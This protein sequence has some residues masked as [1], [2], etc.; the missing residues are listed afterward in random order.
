MG[1]P[2]CGVDYSEAGRQGLQYSELFNKEIR[3]YSTYDVDRSL[4]HVFDGLKTSQRKVLFACFKKK[5]KN[6]IKVAQLAGYIGEHSA[7]HHGEQSLHST[8]I[9][10]AQNYVG[11]NN[12]NLL[13]PSGQFGTRRMGGKSRDFLDTSLFSHDISRLS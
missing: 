10:M 3:A 12:I 7:Y 1:Q 9:G 2:S 4:P 6:E 13:Y 5:L 8:I 11:T